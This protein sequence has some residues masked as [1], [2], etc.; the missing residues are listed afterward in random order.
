MIWFNIEIKTFINT[1]YTISQ[2]WVNKNDNI[3][4]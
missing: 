2:L 4:N 3:N 1:N